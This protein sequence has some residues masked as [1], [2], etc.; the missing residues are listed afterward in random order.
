VRKKIFC[1]EQRLQFHDE[2]TRLSQFFFDKF[3]DLM[4][5]DFESIIYTSLQRKLNGKEINLDEQLEKYKEYYQ[6]MLEQANTEYLE[7]RDKEFG[8]FKVGDIVEFTYKHYFLERPN[9]CK[10]QAFVKEIDTTEFMLKI[11]IIEN[12]LGEGYYEVFSETYSKEN[13]MFIPNS[14]EII[15]I[16]PN[17]EILWT[18][19]FL[20]EKIK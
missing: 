16:I 15:N 6:K 12:C 14:E 7:R 18:D 19:Y 11:V 9:D 2:S 13:E 3:I 20:W 4:P 17:G 5:L 1:L 10:S 8:E